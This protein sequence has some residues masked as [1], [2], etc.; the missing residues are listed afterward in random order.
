MTI[1]IP[2]KKDGETKFL[3]NHSVIFDGTFQIFFWKIM[4]GI[5]LP[6]TQEFLKMS[7]L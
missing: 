6:T 4:V 7:K 1:K 3:K 2:C 5:G